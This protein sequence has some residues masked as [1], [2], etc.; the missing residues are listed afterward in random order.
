LVVKNASPA[1]FERDG[2]AG[3]IILQVWSDANAA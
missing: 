1:V 2:K 3:K